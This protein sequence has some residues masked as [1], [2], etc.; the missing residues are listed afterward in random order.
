MNESKMQF[1]VESARVDEHSSLARCR[2]AGSASVPMAGNAT[3][4]PGTTIK[5]V[6]RRTE[7]RAA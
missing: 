7:P 3:V 2:S 1:H 4:A 6:M 5:G